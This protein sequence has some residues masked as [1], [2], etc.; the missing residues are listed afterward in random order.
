M[1]VRSRQGRED[2]LEFGRG[3]VLVREVGEGEPVLLINGIGAHT[4]MWALMERTLADLRVISFDAP[5]AG[6]S[7]TPYGPVSVPHLARLAAA[8]LDHVEVDRADV[9]G[10]SMGGIVAQQ[11]CADAP[12]RI[13]R[14]VLIGTTPG[15]GAVYGPAMSLLNVSTPVRFFSDS[16]YLRS[17]GKLVGG[18]ARTDPEWVRAQ[19]PVRLA[20]K[21]GILGYCQQVASLATWSGM[22]RLAQI[23]HPVLVV[24]GDDDPL[25]PLANA[26]I[27]AHL[28]PD[29]RLHIA[30]GEG[31]L[32][33]LDDTSGVPDL[34]RDYLAAVDLAAAPVWRDAAQ[35]DYAALAQALAGTG[36]QLQPLPWTVFGA[37][38]RRRWI[39][40]ADH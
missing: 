19:L 36:R 25:A 30:R 11:L 28:I 23:P 40:P 38:Q 14:V 10:Y 15:I 32:M 21:P 17:V 37:L 12:H 18:R 22:A 2:Y 31:H 7:S 26:K 1:T 24:A 39:K 13:R 16:L 6:R 29:A 35:V 34:V 20:H 5:G 9:I 8:V 3:R 33:P 27:L 4:R